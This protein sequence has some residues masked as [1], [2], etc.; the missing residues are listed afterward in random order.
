MTL[1][2]PTPS[3]ARA[4]T[5]WRPGTPGTSPSPL[6]CRASRRD[7]QA[8]PPGGGGRGV[9]DAPLPLLALGAL[10]PR[11]LGGLLAPGHAGGG[12]EPVG[13]R[14]DRAPGPLSPRDRL[15]GISPPRSDH[16]RGAHR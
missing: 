15:A 13:R 14:V 8:D 10:G 11:T 7:R 5:P 3:A 12:V 16:H 1:T 9:G 4:T 6:S 2:G